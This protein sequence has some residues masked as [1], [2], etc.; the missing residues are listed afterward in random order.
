MFYIYILKWNITDILKIRDLIIFSIFTIFYTMYIFFL[1]ESGDVFSPAPLSYATANR[2]A[3]NSKCTI[4]L[5]IFREIETS[6]FGLD[7]PLSTK[8]FSLRALSTILPPSIQLSI[9]FQV[10]PR[11]P[12]YLSFSPSYS[13]FYHHSNKTFSIVQGT[14]YTVYSTPYTVHSVLKVPQCLPMFCEQTILKNP[15]KNWLFSA[16]NILSPFINLCVLYDIT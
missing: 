6:W 12:L 13:R 8:V 7:C 16:K 9:Y 4:K 10:N 3:M 11:P 2:S 14:Q 1:N 15:L 5:L